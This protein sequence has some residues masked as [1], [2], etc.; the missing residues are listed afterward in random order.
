MA[1][2]TD[3]QTALTELQDVRTQVK[4]QLDS[5]VANVSA[6]NA[7]VADFQAKIKAQQDTIALEQSHA[8]TLTRILN[9]LDVALVDLGNEE[10]PPSTAMPGGGTSPS[11]GPASPSTTSAPSPPTTTTGTAP[12]FTV[13]PG[14]GQ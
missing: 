1:G 13:T 3:P 10:G 6:G 12:T 2:T 9:E 5:H 14:V 4:S 8:D 11:T 7:A